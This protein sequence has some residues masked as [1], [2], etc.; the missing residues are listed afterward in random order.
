M[1]FLFLFLIFSIF[2]VL[3][4][5]AYEHGLIGFTGEYAL[6]NDDSPVSVIVLFKNSPAAVQIREA[7]AEGIFLPSATAARN[8]EDDHSL[9]RAELSELF[10]VAGMARTTTPYSIDWDY[11][12]VLNGVSVTMPS[13]K[14]AEL[15]NFQSV[16]FVFPD[17]VIYPPEDTTVTL[18]DTDRNPQGMALG[19]A[20]MRAD[21][22]HARGYRGE[23]ILISVIDTGIYY[24]HEAFIG[25][26]PTLKEMQARNPAIT[27][28]HAIDGIFYGRNFHTVD[29]TAANDPMETVNISIHGTHVSGTIAGR[30]AGGSR[31]VLGVAP[32]A[33][34]I[35]YRVMGAG[36]GST[37]VLVAAIDR[38]PLDKPD[39]VNIS[40]GIEGNNDPVSLLALEVNRGTRAYPY[41]TFVVAAGNSGS[42]GYN[43]I[44][45]PG[46]ATTAIT[47]G[48][49]SVTSQGGGNF[50]KTLEFRSSRGPLNRS[51]EIKPDILAHGTSVFSTL[52]PWASSS[53]YG[54]QTGT[55]MATPHISGAVALM[56][57]F[58]RENSNITW[59][60]EEIKSRIMNT[61]TPLT[62]GSV[63]STGAGYIDV[64]AATHTDT[65]VSVNYDRVATHAQAFNSSD[66]MTA[67]TGSF[68]F[69]GSEYVGT[70]ITR[71]L[72]AAIAN[73]SYTPRTYTITHRFANNPGGV[74]LTLPESVH[75]LPGGQTDFTATFFLNAAHAGPGFFEGFIYVSHDNETVAR[76]PFAY[77]ATDTR[78]PRHGSV[79]GNGRVT[80]SDATQ[81]ARWLAGHNI[82]INLRAADINCD[83]DI[84]SADLTRLARAL[85]G[86]YTT[87]CPYGGCWRCQ[88]M[89][90]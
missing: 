41:I 53:F 46:A 61:A 17:E 43:T 14:V 37:S 45:T 6:A 19:R 59:T 81:L 2:A 47:V 24:N 65:V 29:G 79:N 74:I 86:Q 90:G 39:I 16:R 76:L 83:G 21:E 11:R 9:F 89:T 18:M 80:S 50:G 71:T 22:M 42:Q 4:V 88:G 66:F 1:K 12:N 60:S 20:S 78:T 30:D 72:T 69:G 85:V 57:Q 63:Y 87:L 62:S 84:T 31:A 25:A 36:S 56:K 54:N 49:A 15:I 48:N 10:G 27:E 73:N 13:N 38:A 51:F 5:Y 33:K 75:V 26:F 68:S 7:E 35:V 23:G 34:I 77:T 58:N 67:R 52:P 70:D 3:P 82:T 8:A 55:S 64:F 40:L 32:E 44:G 28:A